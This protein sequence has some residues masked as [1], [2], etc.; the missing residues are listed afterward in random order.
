MTMH[1]PDM[2]QPSIRDYDPEKDRAETA[3]RLA[4][5]E[6]V[7]ELTAGID[8]D[9]L[10]TVLTFGSAQA[11]RAGSAADDV[12]RDIAAPAGTDPTALLTELSGVMDGFDPA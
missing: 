5:S 9:D 1:R 11:R 2:P 10:T 6:L 8:I 7:E 4:H 3:G 12:L